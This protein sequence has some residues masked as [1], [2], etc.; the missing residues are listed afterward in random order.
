M[1]LENPK[2][3]A[4]ARKLAQRDNSF[5]EADRACQAPALDRIARLAFR[6]IDSTISDNTRADM[7]HPRRQQTRALTLFL[8]S[9]IPFVYVCMHVRTHERG[10]G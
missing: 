5:N 2:L 10:G 7:Q 4:Q 3:V 8:P 6:I 1:N 9:I